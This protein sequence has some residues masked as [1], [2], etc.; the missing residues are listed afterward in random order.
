MSKPLIKICGI[1]RMEDA[2]ICASLGIQALGFNFYD[3][4]P[5]YISPN[6]AATIIEGLPPTIWTVALFV[7]SP[8]TRVNEILNI[9]KANTIQL[10]GDEDCDYLK[11][12]PNIRKIKALRLKDN[13]TLK[14]LNSWTGIS[15]FLLFDTWQA[16][17]FG[18][19]GKELNEEIFAGIPEEAK[20]RILSK[21]FIAGGITPENINCKIKS[22][23]PFGL[24]IA[25]GVESSPGVKNHLLIA[26]LMG[27]LSL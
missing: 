2:L 13:L 6:D 5:R 24:D 17:Q 3:K 7:N 4:S 20:R 27:K 21:S 12:L 9:T 10:H 25:S 11:Q 14:G 26:Q 16:D 23:Q 18:G 8:L 15:D 1:T 22:F 19:S